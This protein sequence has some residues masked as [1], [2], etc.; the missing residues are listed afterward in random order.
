MKT[1][2]TSQPAHAAHPP[3]CLIDTS[4]DD[5]CWKNFDSSFQDWF[6]RIVELTV[7][8]VLQNL[9]IKKIPPSSEL[10]FS[11]L[12]TDD[13]R[14]QILNKD[15]RAKNSPT[16]V[17]SFPDT[18]LSEET[19]LSATLFD[20]PLTL[21]DV[22]FAEQTIKR[23]A[24]E[25]NKSLKSHFAHLTIHGILHL[26]GYDHI[27]D[28]EAV[29]MENLEIQILKKLNIKNPYMV[30]DISKGVVPTENE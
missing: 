28:D 21:G 7:E 1:R 16:N 4:I 15:Y 27:Q 5:N 23:E 20:E 10:E 2:K 30:N 22:V 19:L 9:L 12:F 8:N 14:I 25:Q 6:T 26:A 24:E 13:A 18:D 29:E 17:L 11:F 3:K